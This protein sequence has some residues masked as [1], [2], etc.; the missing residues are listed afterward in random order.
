MNLLT[1]AREVRHY[2]S[3]NWRQYMHTAADSNGREYQYLKLTGTG[4]FFPALHLN[5]TLVGHPIPEYMHALEYMIVY[6]YNQSDTE[7]AGSKMNL[8]K[9]KL[10]TLLHDDAFLAL[11]FLSINGP[12]FENLDIEL[13]VKRWMAEGHF[14]PEFKDPR[15]ASAPAK[16][17]NRHAAEDVARGGI[18]LK[19]R[20]LKGPQ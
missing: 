15:S 7:R 16:V 10:R 14:L 13:L 17:L 4:G 20:S 3:E 1:Q 9:T 6:K 11:T 12:G 18:L 5:Q 2:I 19:R 8:I